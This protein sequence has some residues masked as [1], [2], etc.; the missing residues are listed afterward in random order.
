MDGRE[1]RVPLGALRDHLSPPLSPSVSASLAH[2][3]IH[4]YTL[5][6]HTYASPRVTS[7]SSTFSIFRIFDI[8]SVELYHPYQPLSHLSVENMHIESTYTLFLT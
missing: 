2:L 3:T 7:L 8:H 6:I 5:T 1:I 4:S